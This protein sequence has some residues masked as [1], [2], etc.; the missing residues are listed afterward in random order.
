MVSWNNAGVANQPE[1]NSHISYCVTAMS[2]KGT[3]ENNPIPSS[4]TH[5]PFLS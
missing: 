1:T 5:V 2:H 3:H 4:L